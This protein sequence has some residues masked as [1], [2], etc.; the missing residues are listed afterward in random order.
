ML[1]HVTYL[2]KFNLQYAETL[3]KDLS[4]EQMVQQPNGVV[5]HPAWSLGHLVLS[6]NQLGQFVG[7]ASALLTGWDETFKSGRIPGGETPS[8][9]PD[10]ADGLRLWAS[11][12][13]GR[14]GTGDAHHHQVEHSEATGR[15]AY[16]LDGLTLA[17]S[18]T[19]CTRALPVAP[20]A[21]PGYAH[22]SCRTMSVCPN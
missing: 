20:P 19:R 13:S 12:P 7:L 9:A 11:E 6:A 15:D 14:A 5:N 17:L 10:G 8:I 21:A 3:V 1:E 2:Y 22:R 4:T 16:G 18:P